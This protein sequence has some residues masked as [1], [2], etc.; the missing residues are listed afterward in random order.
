MNCVST[1]IWNRD[2]EKVVLHTM[3]VSFQDQIWQVA[4]TAPGV[5]DLFGRMGALLKDHQLHISHMTI[6]GEEIYE[7]YQ[8][9]IKQQLNEINRVQVNVVT[10][11]QFIDELITSSYSYCVQ[12]VQQLPELS[13]QF[14]QTPAQEA[15]QQF[16]SFLE[17][18]EWLN[19]LIGLIG[20]QA[21]LYN[22]AAAFSEI[23]SALNQV[24]SELLE[25]ME[26]Q[27]H[28]VI[29]DL[30]QYEIVPL[31]EKLQHELHQTIGEGV[32]LNDTER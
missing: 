4:N 15:W 12:V 9:R 24:M 8:E 16:Q 6:D 14:Y 30:L 20:E 3:E 1:D 2:N 21:S 28:T 22:N 13:S 31:I 18:V 5:E 17:G 32:S 10:M 27:E 29:G 25:G 7:D 11:K 23:G 26:R 19:Q